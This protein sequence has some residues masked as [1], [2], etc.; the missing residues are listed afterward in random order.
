MKNITNFCAYLEKQLSHGKKYVA[1]DTIS[2]G[3]FAAIGVVFA[4][5]HNDALAGGADFTDKGKNIVPEYKHFAAWVE[6]LKVELASY[7]ANRC[8]APL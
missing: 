8:V 3:D 4:Y 7:L 1:G 6:N 5:I 2:I